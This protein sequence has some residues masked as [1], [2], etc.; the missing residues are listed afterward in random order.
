M[1]KIFQD[2]FLKNAKI[3]AQPNLFNPIVL[4][5]SMDEEKKRQ[6]ILKA[7][8]LEKQAQEIEQQLSLITNEVRELYSLKENLS[9]I[10]V[11]GQQN[12]FASLGKGIFIE[13]QKIDSPNFLVDVG[14]GIIVKKKHDQINILIRHQVQKFE[15]AREE[16]LQRLNI[17]HSLLQELTQEARSLEHSHAHEHEGHEHRHHY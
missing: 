7:S 8:F 11:S 16:L 3:H 4:R 17:Y 2:L 15:Q 5:E 12:I 6:L 9:A 1:N 14:A 13:A 10:N